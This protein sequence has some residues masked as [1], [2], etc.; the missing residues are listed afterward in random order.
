[1]NLNQIVQTLEN[2][3]ADS[4]YDFGNKHFEKGSAED[5]CDIIILDQALASLKLLQSKETSIIFN[6]ADMK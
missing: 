6:Q 4:K 3:A 2:A 1:M 5:L